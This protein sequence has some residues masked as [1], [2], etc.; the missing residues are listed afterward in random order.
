MQALGVR[1][2]TWRANHG[3]SLTHERRNR[4]GSRA[5][6]AAPA[7]LPAQAAQGRGA[8]AAGSVRLM[9]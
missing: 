5:K 8:Q 3:K 6:A 7:A 1:G 2:A 4:R 9:Q